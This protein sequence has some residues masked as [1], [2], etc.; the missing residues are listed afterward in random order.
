MSDTKNEYEVHE[1]KNIF[2]YSMYCIVY[3]ILQGSTI[4]IHLKQYK[5]NTQNS[6]AVN[7]VLQFTKRAQDI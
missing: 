2:I 5:I 1:H 7:S 6:H 4:H 3:I